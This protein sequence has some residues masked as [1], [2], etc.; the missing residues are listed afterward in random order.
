MPVGHEDETGRRPSVAL[1]ECDHV[2]TDLRHVA[3]DYGDMFRRLFAD[4]APDVA[5]DPVDVVGGASLPELGAHDGL[6][7]TGSR[8]SVGDDAPWI[9]GLGE[10][11]VGAHERDVPVVG[12]CF[13]H[14]LIAHVLGGRVDRTPVG[15][16]VGVHHATVVAPR[17]W[18]TPVR[19]G[20]DLLVSHQDQVTTIPDGASVL[21]TS[22]HAPVAAFEVGS[23]VGFQ[24]HPEFVADYAEVLMDRRVER[25]GTERIERAR[26]TL[27]R[28]TDHATITRWIGRFLTGSRE[29]ASAVGPG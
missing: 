16:G 13:G 12:I 7:I 9:A 25:I 24:G 20:F 22:D 4:H 11:I 8:S 6:L 3:G 18:M 23:L 14:Q 15:W 21:A 10:L 27:A 17:A 19:T 26:G 1:L 2:D 28:R 29:S 5:L